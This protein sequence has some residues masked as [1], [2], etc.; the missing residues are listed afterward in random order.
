MQQKLSLHGRCL[1]EF[2]CNRSTAVSSGR[3]SVLLSSSATIT[4]S[5]V[6]VQGLSKLRLMN[7]LQQVLWEVGM[8]SYCYSRHSFHLGVATVA[9][10]LGVSD[11]LMKVLGWWKSS[12]FTR[13]IWIVCCLFSGGDSVDS[14]GWIPIDT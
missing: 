6:S 2:G 8:N 1:V 4:G 10:K 9:A 11:S 7:Y 14:A 12:V 3:T 13:Y 5:S